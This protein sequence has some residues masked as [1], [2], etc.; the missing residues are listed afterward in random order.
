MLP[1]LVQGISAT[2]TH[3][4]PSDQL[5]QSMRPRLPSASVQPPADLSGLGHMVGLL[6]SPIDLPFSPWLW[7][8]LQGHVP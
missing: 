4:A 5:L 8:L 3:S 2:L 7:L 6:T 1:L